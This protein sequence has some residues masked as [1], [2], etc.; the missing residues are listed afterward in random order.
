LDRE[1]PAEAEAAAQSIQFDLSLAYAKMLLRIR[2]Q[3]LKLLQWVFFA[4]EPL[5]LEQLRFAIAI[6][7]GMTDLDPKRQLSFPSFI[8]WAL[9]LLVV[10]S[11][12]SLVRFAHLTIKDYLANHSPKY[13]PDG[14]GLLAKTC[15]TYLSFSALSTDTGQTRFREDGDLYSFFEYAESNWGHHARESE[16]D[17]TSCDM[18]LDWLLSKNFTQVRDGRSVSRWCNGWQFGVD[19]SPLHETCFFG[20]HSLTAKLLESG[21]ADINARDSDQVTPLLYAVRC[22]HLAVVKGLCQCP[23]LDVNVQNNFGYRLVTSPSEMNLQFR[24]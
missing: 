24:P 12:Q 9:G 4:I 16:D 15:L 3:G 23:N 11:E 6:K 14:H 20:L 22:H 13:F 5:T 21:S 1:S 17:T 7:E 2:P 19:Y 10:D 8:D 18:T